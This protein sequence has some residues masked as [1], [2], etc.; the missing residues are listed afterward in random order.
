MKT[1]YKK[2]A[3]ITFAQKGINVAVHIFYELTKNIYYAMSLV[4]SVAFSM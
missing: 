1:A 2:S 3:H 4:S